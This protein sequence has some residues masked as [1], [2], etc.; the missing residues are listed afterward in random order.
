MQNQRNAI[1]QLTAAHLFGTAELAAGDSQ[2][3]ATE[4]RLNLVLR[5]VFAAESPQYAIAIISSGSNGLEE[6]YA[7]GDQVP[8][9]AKLREVNPDDVILERNGQ[10]EILKLVKDTD[11]IDL[12]STSSGSESAA[13]IMGGSNPGEALGQIRKSIM[14]NPTSFGDFALPVVVKENGKQVGY[15]LQPQENGKELLSQIGLEPND[16][17]VSIN[18]VKLDNPQN[19]ISALRKLSTAQSFNLTVKRNGIEVPLNIQLQ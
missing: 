2:Q 8:G 6:I 18:D 16:V 15:R 9:N 11:G 12:V 13:A 19:G 7:I 5:G 10:L 17:I 4:T 1:G 3:V 14:R